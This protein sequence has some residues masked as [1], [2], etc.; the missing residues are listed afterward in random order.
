[1]LSWVIRN[2]SPGLLISVPSQT[3][4]ASLCKTSCM[5][6]TYHAD[7]CCYEVAEPIEPF[8]IGLKVTGLLVTET[9]LGRKEHTKTCNCSS[10][11]CLMAK[12][13][14]HKG[15]HLATSLSHTE[16][17]VPEHKKTA[18]EKTV[19][20]ASLWGKNISLYSREHSG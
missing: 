17:T 11:S 14:L 15:N 16:K 7:F 5:L 18:K 13:P 9:R 20:V 19:L 10:V 8:H 3:G 2:K 12:Y 1:M 4:T 6:P